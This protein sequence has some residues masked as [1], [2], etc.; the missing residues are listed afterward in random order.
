MLRHDRQ[1][2]PGLVALYIQPGKTERVYSYNPGVRTRCQGNTE[3]T[4]KLI[5]CARHIMFPKLQQ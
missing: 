3:I 1:T 5:E 2:K 4:I